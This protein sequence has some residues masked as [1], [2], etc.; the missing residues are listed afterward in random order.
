MEKPSAL[1]AI[2]LMTLA[3][4]IRGAAERSEAMAMLRMAAGTSLRMAEV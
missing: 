1:V 3:I 2:S 4:N